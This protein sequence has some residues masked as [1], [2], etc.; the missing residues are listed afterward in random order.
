MGLADFD[1][2]F[3]M[4]GEKGRPHLVGEKDHLFRQGRDGTY[5]GKEGVL[6]SLNALRDNDTPETAAG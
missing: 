3:F 4:I 2:F 6:K 1:P 5:Q